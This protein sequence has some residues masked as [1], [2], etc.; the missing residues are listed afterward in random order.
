MSLESARQAGQCSPA[1][2]SEGFKGSVQQRSS[3]PSIT[4]A[5]CSSPHCAELL[6]SWEVVFSFISQ[7]H[8]SLYSPRSL[9]R[10]LS[11]TLSL[12][13]FSLFPAGAPQCSILLP[14][15]F[16]WPEVDHLL[17]WGPPFE[18]LETVLEIKNKYPKSTSPQGCVLASGWLKGKSQEVQREKHKCWKNN[19]AAFLPCYKYF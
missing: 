16:L 8:S 4:N 13:H 7:S 3:L 12:S 11:G 14:V 5:S 2:G 19:L 15:L 17:P 9:A 10:P 1:E 18:S 6:E